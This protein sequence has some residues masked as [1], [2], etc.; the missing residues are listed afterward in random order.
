MEDGL[1]RRKVYAFPKC[2]PVSAD[3]ASECPSDGHRPM[4]NKQATLPYFLVVLLY[5]N[6]AP[7]KV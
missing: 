7:R 1:W 6:E 5:I 2:S 3:V 4:I